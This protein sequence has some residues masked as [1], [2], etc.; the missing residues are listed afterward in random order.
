[1]GFKGTII[2]TIT[3]TI[4][5]IIAIIAITIMNQEEIIISILI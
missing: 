4:I 5:T 1:M 2:S 3:E